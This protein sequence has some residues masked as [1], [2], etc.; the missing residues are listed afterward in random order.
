[1]RQNL[2]EFRKVRALAP[3]LTASVSIMHVN[4]VVLML[5]EHLVVVLFVH[6]ASCQLNRG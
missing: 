1:M 2:G 3:T 6:E 4:V 5:S